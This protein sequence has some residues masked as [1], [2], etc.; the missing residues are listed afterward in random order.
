MHGL[1]TK[2]CPRRLEPEDRLEPD[3][4]HPCRRAR[5][6]GPAAAADVRRVRVDVGGDDVGLDLVALELGRRAACGDRD[7][8]CGTARSPRR[9]CRARASAMHHPERGVR[10]LAAVLAHARDVALDVA[11]IERR[12]RSNGGVSSRITRP[13]RRTRWARTGVHRPL[14]AAR[15]GPRRRAPP[16]TARSSRC[17]TPRSAP[18]R[19]AC[20]RRSRRGDTSRRPRP[21]RCACAMRLAS[22][23]VRAARSPSPRASATRGEVPQHLRQEPAEPHA[24]AAAL[25]ADAVHAVVPVAVPMSGRP[26]GPE[27]ER[28]VDR[29]DAVLVEGVR[30]RGDRGLAVAPRARRPRAAGLEEGQRL[31][32]H[33]ASPVASMYCTPRRAATAGRRSSRVRTPAPVCGCHQC[34]TSPSMNWRAAA[35]SRCS[36]KS[37][38]R[39]EG[40]RAHVLQLVAEAERAAGLVEAGARPEPADTSGR[41]ASG[42]SC[43][44]TNRRASSPGP[45]RAAVPRLRSTSPR[46]RA[47]RA[48]RARTSASAA[49]RSAPWPSTNTIW[50]VSP[51]ARVERA[52][53]GRR[54]IEPGAEAVPSSARPSAA[55]GPSSRS[56]R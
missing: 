20:R 36:R 46:P 4:V 50:P 13:S 25:E 39:G 6:P 37:S 43:S 11:G 56:G 5:V 35:R 45:R 2:A 51:G 7:S 31:V 8:A 28:C 42:S 29:A 12:A 38:G 18:S 54:R 16:R 47:R 3:A 33:A 14:G 17:G 9:R 19:A 44:R 53:G 22:L 55:G 34:W 1:S 27:R 49:S 48:S 24:L 52:R 15:A 40:Q 10:V 21:A 32:E 26:C 30:L 41:A 23:A